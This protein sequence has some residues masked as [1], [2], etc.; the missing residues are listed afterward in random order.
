MD[1]FAAKVIIVEGTLEDVMDGDHNHVTLTL[2]FVIKRVA[3]LSLNRVSVIF[4]GSVE[5]AAGVAYAILKLRAVD[6]ENLYGN[7]G[8]D[9]GNS[10]ATGT[11]ADMGVPEARHKMDNPECP[12]GLGAKMYRQ[13]DSG[14]RAEAR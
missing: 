13:R 7:D 14:V 2:G 12:A 11:G 1:N 3:R 9:Q 5:M 10:G 4:A 8:A 6:L